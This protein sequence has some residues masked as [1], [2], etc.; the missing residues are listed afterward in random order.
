MI[1]VY[2]TRTSTPPPH[3]AV[4]NSMPLPLSTTPEI[5]LPSNE[6]TAWALPQHN[7]GSVD[8]QWQGS[9]QCMGIP[10]SC[11]PAYYSN[12]ASSSSTPRRHTP[13]PGGHQSGRCNG[14]QPLVGNYTVLV[15]P[16][17]VC[18]CLNKVCN[19]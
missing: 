13:F 11:V 17:S 15:F 19:T 1:K 16:Y 7:T 9:I 8:Q 18:I 14:S 5:Q 10:S 12:S 4:A 6:V 3:M 2:Y